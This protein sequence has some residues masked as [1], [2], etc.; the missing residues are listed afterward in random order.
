ML[1][2]GNLAF[3]SYIIGAFPV[4]YFLYYSPKVAALIL[5][6]A[7]KFYRKKQHLLL[8]DFCYWA[9]FLCLFY[10]WCMPKSPVL[11]QVIF[12]VANGPLAWSALNALTA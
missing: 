10:C 12:V 9:N 3:S 8:F 11:F 7:V 5:L 1:G 6:R 4:L 2:V